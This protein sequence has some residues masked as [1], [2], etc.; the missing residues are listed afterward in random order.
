M[1][2]P[3]RHRIFAGLYVCL[4]AV[5]AVTVIWSMRQ[6][7][8]V[9][10]LRRGVGDTWFYAADGRAWFRMDEQRRDVALAQIAPELRNAVIAVEDHRFFSHIG[11]DPIGLGRA[12]YRDLRYQRLEGGSTLTQQLARTLFLSNKKTP[13]RKAQEAVLALLL[14]QELSKDQILELY[15]NRIYLSGGV[16]GVETMSRNLY[17]KPASAL[18]LPEAALIA[19][20]I[21]APSA[22]SP[23]SNLDGALDR[24]RVVLQRMRE[25]GFIT[26]AQERAAAQVR[27][28]IRPYPGAT[29]AQF[30]YAKEFLRQQFRDRFGG[31]HPPDWQVRTTFVPELQEAAERAVENGLRRFGNQELQAA[32]VAIDP[33]TGDVLALVGGR[34]FRQSQ[35]NRAWRSRRQPGSAFKPF[36]FA[37]ALARGY[38][39]VSVLDGLMSIEPQGPEE[40]APR[41]SNDVAAEALTLRAALIESNNRAA[42]LLQQRI[43]ARPVLRL[44][45]DVGLRDLPDVPSL[46]LGTGL[47]TPLDL[48]A[49]FAVFPNGGSAVRPRALTRVVDADG[50]VAFDNPA[51][52]DRVISPEIAFQMV[53]MLEDVVNRGTGSP[54]RSAYGVRFPAGGKTGT[55]DDFKDAWF[56]GFTTSTVVGVWVGED[57]P[58][59]IGREGYGARYALPIWSDFIKAAARKRGAR[60]FSIPSNLHDELLCA[61]SYLKPVEGCPTYTEYFKEGD[62]IPS[63]LCPI[64]KGSVKQQIKRA[65]QG[66]FSGLGRKL[67]GIF[68]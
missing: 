45:S 47:V 10:K 3:V 41:N 26:A 66:L 67:K 28:R 49:A 62:E 50:G 2:R 38:S 14:E 42:A 15:L 55:T 32:L 19:G 43:G 34:D 33:A 30:G 6:G 39:P 57:Q 44:A 27:P 1:T 18:T 46:S 13:L 31:D 68:K 48:T 52:Q 37:A 16:Y 12:V 4:V 21:R 25:E 64:H 51:R 63:R 35:F 40:W 36:L 17:G 24:S 29:E 60:E 22:L 53:S 59:T 8:A 9:Y 7:W 58:D 20:L 56:V 54:A 23:W 65:V 11:I 61:E 5:T